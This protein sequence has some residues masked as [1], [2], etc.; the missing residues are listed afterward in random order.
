MRTDQLA[1]TREE[2]AVVREVLKALREIR[3]GYVQVH[4]QDARVMH[5]EKVE[6]VRVAPPSRSSSRADT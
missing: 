5:I 1:W 3:Y 2:E 6:K 4:M